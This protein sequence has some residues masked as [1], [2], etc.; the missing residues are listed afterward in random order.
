MF[1]MDVGFKHGDR[2][3]LSLYGEGYYALG[4]MNDP[5]SLD[6][7]PI[8]FVPGN[9]GSEKQAR[10]LGSVLQNKTELRGTHFKFNVFTIDFKEEFSAFSPSIIHRQIDY[11]VHAIRHVHGLYRDGRK[12]ILY[13]HSIGGIVAQGALTHKD[14][15]DKVSLVIGLS[16]PF[17]EPPISL[18]LGMKKIWDDL[19]H[20]SDIPTISIDAGLLDLQIAPEWTNA[21]FVHH[22]STNELDGVNLECDHQCIVW[23]N[24]L[25]RQNSRFLFDYA[26][27]M[28][29]KN[30]FKAIF[31][32][33]FGPKSSDVLYHAEDELSLDSTIKSTILYNKTIKRATKLPFSFYHHLFVY[34]INIEAKNELKEVE[35]QTKYGFQ[36]AVKNGN[37]FELRAGF[38][39]SP[40]VDELPRLLIDVEKEKS[41]VIITY[42]VDV[43]YSLLKF[44]Q[45]LRGY[46][47][48][49]IFVWALSSPFWNSGKFWVINSIFV[50]SLM[51]VL[52][53]LNQ[54]DEIEFSALVMLSLIGANIMSI[55]ASPLKLVFKYL[56][57]YDTL[58][59]PGYVDITFTLIN[60]IIGV[61]L[62][63]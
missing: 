23:C 38:F 31:Y 62:V 10:S 9:A 30:D 56:S 14:I 55:L 42:K 61:T 36:K 5:G 40:K 50:G 52:K 4:Y 19:Y 3:N 20:K 41:E 2:Y 35:F 16:T 60:P 49:A 24:Q 28:D 7:I 44:C 32:K 51:A 33:N 6:G 57:R 25:V 1:F 13:G 43:K 37:V 45:K 22:V 26:A 12:I 54:M 17:S 58:T 34:D 15:Q 21:P 8:I 63:C 48:A 39:N 53:G 59:T 18:G 29:F 27:S 11:L 47:M 46:L